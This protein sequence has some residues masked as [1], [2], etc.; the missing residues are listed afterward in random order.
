MKVLRN[1]VLCAL[2]SLIWFAVQDGH[3]V[4]SFCAFVGI[5]RSWETMALYTARATPAVLLEVYLRM[6]I[7]VAVATLVDGVCWSCSLDVVP[8]SLSSATCCRLA[9]SSLNPL[10]SSLLPPSPAVGAEFLPS[11]NAHVHHPQAPKV[12]VFEAEVTFCR[13]RENVRTSFGIRP[14]SMRLGVLP[15]S[16]LARIVNPL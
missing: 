11:L 10:L 1:N 16:L 6:A 9:W 15:H 12:G 4:F 7:P 5:H 14:S 13:S 8:R 2:H 3:V